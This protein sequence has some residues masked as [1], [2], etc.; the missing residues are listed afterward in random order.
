MGA[1]APLAEELRRFDRAGGL[2]CFFNQPFKITT[3][4]CED[5]GRLS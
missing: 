5:Y 3:K 4:F 2:A 1:C